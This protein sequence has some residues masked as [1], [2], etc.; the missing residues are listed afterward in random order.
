MNQSLLTVKEAS[1]FLHVHPKTLYKWTNEGKVPFRKING[2]LRFSHKDIENGPGSRPE[3]FPALLESFPKLSLCLADYDRMHLKGG[4]SALGKNSKRWNYGFGAIY[5]RKTKK[6]KDR[7]CIDY[8]DG[9]ARRQRHVVK[10]AQ[11]RGEALIALQSEV[12]EVFNGKFHPRRKLESMRFSEMSRIYLDNYAKANKKSWMCDKY[13]LG[14]HLNPYFGSMRLSDLSPLLVEKYRADRL[15]AGIRKSTANRELA[16]LKKIFNLAVDWGF[17][18]SNP[19]IKVKL[20]PEKDNLKERVL[21]EAEE[22]KI[23]RE[24]APHLKPIII[25]ALSTGMRKNEILS[26]MWSNVDV[27]RKTILASKTKSGKNRTIPINTVLV[28]VLEDLKAGSRSEF[29]FSG[30]EG[31]GIRTVRRAFANACRRAGVNGLRFHDLRHTFATRLIRKGV[32]I[33]TVQNLLGHHSVT[34]TQRYT[35]TD[36]GQKREAVELLASQTAKTPEDLSHIWHTEGGKGKPIL[37][38]SLFSVN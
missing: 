26:L 16:L 35:H 21:S 2:L 25:T 37:S 28:K 27:G 4:K 30:P 14:A 8:R 1:S 7:W 36:G 6:G 13:C 3:R 10:N 5:L 12:A 29:V 24:S 17:I 22:A 34:V 18:T 15:R 9:Q 31:K 19:V 33:V 20:F 32:D 11:C 23:L 38:N